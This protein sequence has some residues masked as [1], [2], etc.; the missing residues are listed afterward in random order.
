MIKIE[1][2]GILT[3]GYYNDMEASHPV[4]MNGQS[5][6]DVIKDAL[7]DLDLD[8]EFSYYEKE[9]EVTNP[10]KG[11]SVKLTLEINDNEDT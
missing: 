10:L 8:N 3:A 5:I 1:I 6:S 9:G 4:F 11:K 7:F 2:N